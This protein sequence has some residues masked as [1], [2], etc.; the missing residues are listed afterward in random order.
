MTGISE[1]IK[2]EVLIYIWNYFTYIVIYF[3]WVN[4]D[5]TISR[6]ITAC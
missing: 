6:D 5:V 2:F 3:Y 4:I 1:E